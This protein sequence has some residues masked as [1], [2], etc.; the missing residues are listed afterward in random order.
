MIRNMVIAEKNKVDCLFLH[1]KAHKTA[2]PTK[3]KL[4]AKG[5]NE[6]DSVLNGLYCINSI[7]NITN[8]GS[9]VAAKTT[10]VIAPQ[11]I[12]RAIPLPVLQE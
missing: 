12:I 9:I 10:S 5:A 6:E 7:G 3:M 11:P 1:K 4:K 2:I 8:K